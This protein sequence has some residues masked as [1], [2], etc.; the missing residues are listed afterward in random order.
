[1][2]V[3]LASFL[4]LLELINATEYSVTIMNDSKLRDKQGAIHTWLTFESPTSDKQYFSFE[5]THHGKVAAG[6][7]APGSCTQTDEIENR[8]ASE[9]FPITITRQQYQKLIDSSRTLCANPP[10]YDLIPN[11]MNDDHLTTEINERTNRLDYNCVTAANKILQS[12]NINT[13]ASA[14]TPYHVKEIITG[15]RRSIVKSA[16]VFIVDTA[17]RMIA[18]PPIVKPIY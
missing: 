3:V 8:S 6:L 4:F 14:Q 17:R 1:M 9:T 13:I 15:K 2:L 12:A 5:T 7:D 18:L 16:A 10:V 11:N